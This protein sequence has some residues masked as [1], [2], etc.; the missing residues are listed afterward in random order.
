MGSISNIF[1]SRANVPLMLLFAVAANAQPT[2]SPADSR[3]AENECSLCHSCVLPTAENLCLIH[4]CTRKG[5]SP[6]ASRMPYGPSTIVL[7]MLEDA[8]LPVPFDHGGHAKM[9]EMAQGCQTCH[10][11]TPAGRPPPRCE[12]C[13]DPYSAGTD[14]QKPGLRGAFHQQCLGCHRDWTS[15]TDCEK[16]HLRKTDGMSENS[17][18]ATHPDDLIMRTHPPVREPEGEFFGNGAKEG[19]ESRVIFRHSEHVHRFG[20]ACVEC[21]HEPSC[22]RCHQEKSEDRPARPLEHHAPCIHCHK[23]EMTVAARHEGLCDRCHWSEGRPKAEPFNHATVGWP[24]SKFHESQ[25]CRACHVNTPFTKLDR[26]CTSC[27]AGWTPSNFDH[28][29]TG[30]MLDERHKEIECEMCHA[31][32]RFEAKPTCTECHEEEGIAFPAAPPGP[33]GT[34]AGSQ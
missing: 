7:D 8:Y 32:R 15:E 1:H 11:H 28:A 19:A 16:C 4:P 33:L 2:P 9:A 12:T 34:S 30:Q 13:H 26:N 5:Q 10:H 24:L 29:V 27:H 14:I 21:H 17:S 20:L 18:L 23:D 25:S 3:A 31:E 22:S 6:S